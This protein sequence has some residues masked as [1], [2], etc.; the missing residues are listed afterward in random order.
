[1]APAEQEESLSQS[2]ENASALSESEGPPTLSMNCKPS[3]SDGSFM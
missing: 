2:S 1:M 3:A